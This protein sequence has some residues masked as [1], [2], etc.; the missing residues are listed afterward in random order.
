MTEYHGWI[1]IPID[2]DE[3]E[4]TIQKIDLIKDYLKEIDHPHRI[5]IHR[6]M[7]GEYYV[8]LAGRR[9]HRSEF[10]GIEKLLEMLSLN[11]PEAYGLVYLFDDESEWDN[12]FIVYR[13]ARGKISLHEDKLLSPCFPTIM[14]E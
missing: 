14:D 13:L 4:E 6:P 3:R 11:L 2:P 7:N 10:E 12:E 9:N 5:L 1:S 8:S